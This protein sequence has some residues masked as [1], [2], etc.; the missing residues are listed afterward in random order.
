MKKNARHDA[1]RMISGKRRKRA[2]PPGVTIRSIPVDG[3]DY[4]WWPRHGWQVWG[5]DMK[6]ISV[7]VALEPART[8]ELI[9]D[10]TMIVKPDDDA[11]SDTKLLRALEPAI[12]AAMDAGWNPESRGRAFRHAIAEPL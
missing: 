4:Q 12:R 10:F 6:V 8:R 2:A 7:A 1:D 5:K 11:A 3:I 9:L